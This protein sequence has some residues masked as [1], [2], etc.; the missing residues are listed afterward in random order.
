VF[1]S[2]GIMILAAVA[3]TAAALPIPAFRRWAL[4]AFVHGLRLGL[5]AVVLACLVFAFRPDTA[6]AAA[7]AL[8]DFVPDSWRDALADDRPPLAWFLAAALLLAAGLPLLAHFEHARR[9]AD[10]SALLA[11][12]RRQ[13]A[14]TAAALTATPAH[15]A[16]PPATPVQYPEGDV[17]AGMAVLRAVLDAPGRQTPLEAR[18]RLIKDCLASPTR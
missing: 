15:P 11:S 4:A 14:A 3:L 10:L 5:P 1:P 2:Q 18:P 7:S 9:L 17:A 12:L 8:T 13:V 16:A 6:P